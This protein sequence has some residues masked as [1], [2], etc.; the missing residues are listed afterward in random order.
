MAKKHGVKNQSGMKENINNGVKA[1]SKWRISKWR[2]IMAASRIE[3]GVAAKK[4]RHGVASAAS[5]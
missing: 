2:G 3:G 4:Q 5:K 1:A